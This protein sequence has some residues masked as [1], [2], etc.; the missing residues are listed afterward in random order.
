M[1]VALCV[2]A[3][4]EN[5]Y[6]D[7][8]VG[9]YKTLGFSHIYI[10]DNNDVDGE[11]ID[12]AIGKYVEGGFVDVIDCRGEIGAQLKVYND[13]YAKFG[14]G[15][16]WMA[17]FDADEFLT[18]SKESKISS[19][20]D[21][22]SQG[23]FAGKDVVCVTWM[24]YG[25]NGKLRYEPGSV[26]ERFPEP[27]DFDK[28]L[29]YN[30]PENC[31]VKSFLRCGKPLVFANHP[32]CPYS[33]ANGEW[34]ACD[35]NGAPHDNGMPFSPYD[36]S[37]AYLRH[38]LTKTAEEFAENVKRG[39]A[40]LLAD[41]L[42]MRFR[43]EHKFFGV[44]DKTP[45][46]MAVLAENLPWYK[47]GIENFCEVNEWQV[48][49]ERN[50]LQQHVGDLQKQV[51]E[52]QRQICELQQR[53]GDLQRQVD[54]RQQHICELRKQV[55]DL[56]VRYDAIAGSTCWRITKPVRFVLD[57]AKALFRKAGR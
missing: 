29:A 52:R 22:L 25:D 42:F 16:D 19:V 45:S 35:A 20:G 14:A 31:H 10:Y 5:R 23:R 44:N 3:K 24:C 51:D 1:E 6:L 57:C 11:R 28:C 50:M 30:F 26:I 48:L 53:V 41:E 15:Y 13:C 4:K 40:L 34:S 38:Y 46:R 39:Y 49:N 32:H 7:E 37:I 9:Y 18:F 8:F 17:F 27:M 43:V 33:S 2:I 55:D 36:F 47:V 21:F 54:D 56:G 12:D